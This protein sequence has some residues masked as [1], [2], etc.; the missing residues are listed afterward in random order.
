[1]NPT[2]YGVPRPLDTDRQRLVEQHTDLAHIVAWW[3]AKQNRKVPVD[4]FLSAANFGLTYAASRFDSA[5]GVPFKAYARLVIGQQLV[6]AA[7]KWRTGQA[8]QLLENEDGD[9]KVEA[10]VTD[11]DVGAIIDARAACKR[12]RRKIPPRWYKAMRLHLGEGVTLKEAGQRM[13]VS[14]QRVA[15]LVEMGIERARKFMPTL[16]TTEF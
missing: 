10:T 12:L 8:G 11:Q 6:Q 13:G 3:F 16:L 4:E 14:H 1:M 5:R 9:Y 7:I 2:P 15:Q